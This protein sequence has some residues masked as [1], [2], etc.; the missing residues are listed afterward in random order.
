M[1]VLRGCVPLKAA[2]AAAAGSD[3]A[4]GVSAAPGGRD[5]RSWRHKGRGHREISAQKSHEDQRGKGG[6][7][8]FG[9]SRR[10]WLKYGL[11]SGSSEIW[12]GLAYFVSPGLTRR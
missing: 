12:G 9:A 11:T 5:R 4:A 7:E 8:E 3:A 10:M 2:T 6:G 1:R